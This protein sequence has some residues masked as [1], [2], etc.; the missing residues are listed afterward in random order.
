[1]KKERAIISKGLK[2]G[3]YILDFLSTSICETETSL[4]QG[5]LWLS[6]QLAT[7]NFPGAQGGW[8]LSTPGQRGGTET[9]RRKKRKKQLAQMLLSRPL[10]LASCIDSCLFNLT[11]SPAPK[12][13]SS[14]SDKSLLGET[15]AAIKRRSN[16]EVT[17][18]IWGKPDTDR[19]SSLLFPF[20]TCT[21]G[22]MPKGGCVW[23]DTNL[24]SQRRCGGGRTGSHRFGDH[25]AATSIY[26]LWDNC[27]KGSFW[28]QNGH[29]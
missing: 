16:L 12:W 28:L 17:E 11:L 13:Q 27:V 3:L 10:I 24:C 5:K 7:W 18:V 22:R 1:M 19:I 2:S 25:F 26:I 9:A 14:L 20:K 6:F 29:L 4:V 21:W 8:Q 15:V 23:R